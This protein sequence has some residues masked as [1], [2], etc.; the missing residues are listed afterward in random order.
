MRL[1]VY[2]IR[3]GAGT[4]KAFHFPLPFLGYLRNT[5][6]NVHRITEFIKSQ[7]PD[8]VGLIEVD[9]GSFRHEKDNQAE[10]IARELAHFHV[11]E[12]KYGTKSLFGRLPLFNKQ[13]NAFLTSSE[14]RTPRFHYFQA[15]IK[16]LVMELE[17]NEV[18]LFLVHL[19]LKFRHRHHQLSDLYSL[20][21]ASTKPVIVAGDFNPLWGDREMSLFLAATGLR[22]ANARNLPSY[23]SWM[24]HRQLDFILHSPAIRI[25][26][27][28]VPGVRLSDHL[29][30]V[31]DFE[32]EPAR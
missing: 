3:Y 24:P 5:T 9:S 10:R 16:R 7:Q 2:N 27:F 28:E 29:P 23:P 21:K 1:L 25:N 8:I 13:V 4:G 19:S 20:V 12:C 17:L 6:A 30:L 15:G 11:C 32:L 14:I 22:N 18:T 26:R 31:C